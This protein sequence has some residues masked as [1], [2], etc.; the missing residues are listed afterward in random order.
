MYVKLISKDGFEFIIKS[1][2]AFISRQLMAM[3]IGPFHI[4]TLEVHV[5]FL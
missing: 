1:E 3:A 2:Y 4:T 5:P